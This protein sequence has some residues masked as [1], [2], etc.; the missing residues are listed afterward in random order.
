MLRSSDLHT[1]WK[2]ECA[3]IHQA[4]GFLDHNNPCFLRS[5]QP[6]FNTLQWLPIT[7]HVVH[8]GALAWK[9]RACLCSPPFCSPA[10]PPAMPA[11]LSCL[12]NSPSLHTHQ[13]H[14]GPLHFAS[15]A[16]I[17]PKALSLLSYTSST[18]KRISWYLAAEQLWS[19]SS[20]SA[21][22]HCCTGVTSSVQGHLNHTSVLGHLSSLKLSRLFTHFYSHLECELQKPAL[23]FIQHCIPKNR[24]CESAGSPQ[25]FTQCLLKGQ[26]QGNQAIA[27]EFSSHIKTG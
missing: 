24:T 5:Q 20:P 10:L 6:L 22:Q 3:Q 26:R 27:L 9:I 21:S 15:P 23:N 18:E 1:S 17:P 7:S 13:A 19:P 25:T 16:I 14:S 2:A 12:P 8:W 4:E 11:S